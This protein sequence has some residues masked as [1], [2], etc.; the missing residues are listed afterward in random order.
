[1]FYQS[2]SQGVRMR[3]FFQVILV[4]IGFLLVMPVHSLAWEKQDL[5]KDSTYGNLADA[6]LSIDSIHT[7]CVNDTFNISGTT[8]LP[9]GTKLRVM[10]IRGSYNPGIPPQRNPWYDELKKET[11][12]V[13]DSQRGNV[14]VYTLNTTGSYPD[15]YLLIIEPYAGGDVNATAFFN[16]QEICTAS[17][18]TAGT[19]KITPAPVNFTQKQITGLPTQKTADIPFFVPLMAMSG[20]GIIRL[21]TSRK[22]GK[23]NYENE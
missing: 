22:R 18:N 5:S 4:I 13:A 21:L 6:V 3:N 12:V 2:S 10:V 15:E 1:M 23:E 11:R 17:E 20:F 16:L 9:A 19:T 7:H 14:W 8:S